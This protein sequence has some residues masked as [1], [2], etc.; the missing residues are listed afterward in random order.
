M[1]AAIFLMKPEAAD[2]PVAGTPT[3]VPTDAPAEALEAVADPAADDPRT[4]AEPTE[5][6]EPSA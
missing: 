3:V 2:P 6:S 4:P 1:E 5:P